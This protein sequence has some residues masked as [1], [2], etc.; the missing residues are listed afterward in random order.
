MNVCPHC[1][2]DPSLPLW[3]KLTLGPAASAHCQVCGFRVGVDVARA[4]LAMLPTFLLVVAVVLGI[5]SEPITM[6]G[7]LL[8]CLAVMFGLYLFWVPLKPDELTTP[9]M[10]EAGRARI[11]ED[12]KTAMN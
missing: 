3:R 11:A 6:I 12:K 8:L 1:K 4:T 9:S 7:L 5:L 10:V 2:A